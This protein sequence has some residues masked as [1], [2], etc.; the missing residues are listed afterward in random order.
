[1]KV[2]QQYFLASV[3][4]LLVL[5][6]AEDLAVA[7]ARGRTAPAAGSPDPILNGPDWGPCVDG[8]FSPDYVSGMDSYGHPVPPADLQG[9]VTA[10]LPSDTVVPEIFTRGRGLGRVEVPVEIPGLSHASAP[11]PVCAPHHEKG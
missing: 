6:D 9:N 11:P 3:L 7:A 5:G 4:T 1:M 10:A 2:T 8:V